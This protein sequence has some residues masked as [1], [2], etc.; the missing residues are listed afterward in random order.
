M[1]E[2]YELLAKIAQE[3][4][5]Y[6]S[7]RNNFGI[8]KKASPEVLLKILSSMGV[9]IREDLADAADV[10]QALLEK[11]AAQTIEP[12]FVAW[13]GE[14]RGPVLKLK[15]GAKSAPNVSFE[16]RSEETA[17]QESWTLSF[18]ELRWVRSTATNDFFD[19]AFPRPLP[20]GYYRLEILVGSEKFHSTILVAPKRVRRPPELDRKIWGLFA[21]TYSLRREN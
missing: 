12:C 21:P 14:V 17:L 19:W 4:G 18:S 6:L 15:T 16:I 7:Y 1:S 9:Q 13:E 3:M 20:I 11:K 5:I 8:E 2:A 10:L